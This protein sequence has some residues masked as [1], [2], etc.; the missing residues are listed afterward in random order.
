MW[1]DYFGKHSF[2]AACLSVQPRAQSVYLY[3]MV[4][5]FLVLKFTFW[6]PSGFLLATFGASCLQMFRPGHRN[7]GKKKPKAQA[8]RHRRCFVRVP[9]RI[10]NAINLLILFGCY[11][12]Q[13]R[14]AKKVENSSMVGVILAT[15]GG[16]MEVGCTKL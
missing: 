4:E 5:P 6:C 1:L 7:G 14:G 12:C 9:N 2:G 13:S 15:L 3:C 16:R 10:S 8:S 11:T